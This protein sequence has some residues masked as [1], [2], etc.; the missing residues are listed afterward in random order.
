M[1]ELFIQAFKQFVSDIDFYG[2]HCLRSGGATATCNCDVP[3]RLFKR[4]GRWRSENVKDGHVKDSF[5]DLL[6]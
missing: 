6:L 5:N 4:H 1:K 2:L 3:S